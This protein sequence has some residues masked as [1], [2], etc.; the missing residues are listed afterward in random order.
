ME[1]RIYGSLT[2]LFATLLYWI[3]FKKYRSEKYSQCLA[4]IMLGGLLLRVFTSLDFYLHEWDERYHALVAKNLIDNPFKPMLYKYPLMDFDYKDW[5]ANHIWVHK[6]PL[7]IYSMALSMALFGKNVIA[8]RLPSILLSTF[9]IFSTFKIGEMLDSK[10]VGLMAA[11]L[12][13][14]NGLIIE[15]AAGRV[16][17]DHYDVFF[18][19]L[20]CMAVY[21]FLR[22]VKKESIV[23]FLLA[24]VLTGLAILTKWL[25]ALIVLPIWMI[26][27]YQ[28]YSIKRILSYSFLFAVVVISIAVPW[29]LYIMSEFP[30][31]ASYS[32][33]YNKKHFFEALGPHGRPFYFHFDK[34]RIIFGELIYFPFAWL[35]YAVYKKKKSTHL[36]LLFWIVIP[37]IFFSLAVTKMQGYILFCAPAIFLMTALFYNYIQQYKIK[38]P[39]LIKLVSIL[40]F[41]LPIRYSIERIKPFSTIDRNPAWI[42]AL[43]KLDQQT[44]SI[45]KVI[46]NCKHPVEAMFHADVTAYATLPSNEEI[47]AIQSKGYQIYMDYSVAI[48]SP[49]LDRSEIEYVHLSR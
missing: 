31:E 1:N 38:S 22:H 40:L 7:P 14:I 47:N 10:K 12:F 39:I 13:S 15:Q 21:L 26:F 33:G 9:A 41:A 35:I 18:L 19:S 23:S 32:Y 11:F 46:F 34:M 8:L 17:T 24:S 42:S 4:L 20:I 6:Q 16:A 27:A 36:V 37:Y 48:P 28:K 25:P 3:A 45:K 44:P 43:Q 49:L 2:I 29:Q 30:L 5:S